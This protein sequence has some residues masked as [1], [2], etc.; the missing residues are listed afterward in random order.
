VVVYPPR[1]RTLVFCTAF[2]GPSTQPWA[3]W[4]VRYRRWLDA[5]AT[6]HLHYDQI[7]IVD[8][9]SPTLPNWPGTAVMTHLGTQRPAERVVIFHFPD[10][11]GRSAVFEY[12][13]WFRSFTFAATYAKRYGFE[14]IIHIE[15]D[16]F[17]VSQ[18]IQE[19]CNSVEDDWVTFLGPRHGYPE[20]AIQIMVGEGLRRFYEIALRPYSDFAGKPIEMALPFTRVEHQFTGDRYGEYLPYVPA[21]AD[22]TTQIYPPNASSDEY[23]WWMAPRGSDGSKTTYQKETGSELR[24]TGLGYLAFMAT[25]SVHLSC[26]AYFEIGTGSGNTLKAFRCDSVCIDPHFLVSQDVLQG[27]RRAHF[28]QMTSDEFFE[29]NDLKTYLPCGFDIA[30]LDGLHHFE[31]LLR[32]F[33]NTEQCCH[34]RSTMLVHDCLPLNERM[35]ERVM[36]IDE[37]EDPS[38]RDA[39]T[40]DVWRLLPILKKFRPDLRVQQFDCGPTGLVVCTRLDPKSS[41]LSQNYHNIV[42]EFSKL[43]LADFSLKRLWHLF[44]TIDTRKLSCRPTDIP[45]VLFGRTES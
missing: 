14:K 12:P 10:N 45:G 1:Q 41:I 26:R 21:D 9:G 38:T 27:R 43:S 23:Y 25:L 17:L 42:H 4:N 36:R 5:I 35:T 19:F 24:H 44:P 20:A 15:S 11:L 28:F 33:I 29:H 3:S 13:G 32:D 18:R 40:G 8:D 7:L 6:S 16:A 30:F 39:W 34:D 37:A 22:W 2:S 31:V